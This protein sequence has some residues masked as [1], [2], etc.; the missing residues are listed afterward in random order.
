MA[1]IEGEH[2]RREGQSSSGDRGRE[3]RAL[4]T[5]VGTL[6]V[7]LVFGHEKVRS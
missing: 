3:Y 1:L 7:G 2:D 6:A 4:G 5:T